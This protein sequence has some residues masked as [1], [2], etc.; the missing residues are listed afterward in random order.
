MAITDNKT[1]GWNISW[2][3]IGGL[4]AIA[5]VV[6][7]AIHFN[8]LVI[9]YIVMSLVLCA[10]FLIVAFDFGVPAGKRTEGD[11]VGTGRP[12]R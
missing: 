4:V 12:S 3:Q 9:G 11:D 8:S 1:F 2:Q 6:F 7:L 10:L 5:V